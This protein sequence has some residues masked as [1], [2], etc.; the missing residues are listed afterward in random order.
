MKTG[1]QL[2]LGILCLCVEVFSREMMTPSLWSPPILVL[3]VLWLGTRPNNGIGVAWIWFLS[4]LADGFSTSPV[5]THMIPY[6]LIYIITAMLS[7]KLSLHRGFGAAVLGA[8]GIMI[9]LVVMATVTHFTFPEIGMN[10]R[11]STLILPHLL[12]ASLLA[13]LLFPLF[14]RLAGAQTDGGSTMNLGS[15]GI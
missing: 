1:A 4:I 6:G 8:G 10:Q 2:I 3:F 9:H 5:G 13:P 11:L 7:R 12:T 15:K 14:T